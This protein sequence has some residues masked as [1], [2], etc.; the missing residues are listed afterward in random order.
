MPQRIRAASVA[1]LCFVTAAL[2]A[3]TA[4][5]GTVQEADL[6][7]HLTYL[8]SDELTGREVFTEGY[9]VASQYVADE[10][11][12]MGVKPLGDH[13]TYFQMVALK[14]VR[15]TNDSSSVTVTVN[16]ASRTF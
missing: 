1:A 5:T 14:D 10:L 12:A 11:K 8:S 13:G 2:I 3:Q 4:S 7:R 6:R 15:V 9:G 16:G